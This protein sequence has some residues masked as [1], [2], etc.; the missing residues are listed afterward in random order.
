MHTP[1]I[2]IHS[3]N[4]SSSG[5]ITIQNFI[6]SRDRILVDEFQDYFSVGLHPWF[7]ESEE[8]VRN[9]I[10][11]IEIFAL[12]KN[13]LAIGEAG[14]DKVCNT[15]GQL[16]YYAFRCQVE[17]SERLHKPMIIHQVRSPNEVIK[18]RKALRC[19]QPWVIHGFQGSFEQ[20]NQIIENGC[21]ISL[22]K[23]LLKPTLKLLKIGEQ[24]SCDYFFL[25]TDNSDYS[26][27]Q[28]Y[29]AA[30]TLFKVSSEVLKEK[31]YDNFLRVFHP[32]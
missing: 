13:C 29:A 5:E 12:Q 22:G 32:F 25:E 14:L 8:Y 28:I 1:F 23:S 10:T 16:Q 26:I 7:L 9:G 3:H 18:L 27:G 15:P 11:A 30:S 17:L 21:Y 20:A 2:N 31:Q 24:L 6:S 19:T 4:P